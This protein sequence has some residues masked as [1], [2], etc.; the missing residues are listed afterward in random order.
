MSEAK[1]KVIGYAIIETRSQYYWVI[2]S[3]IGKAE[4]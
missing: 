2:A 3:A 4:V 1:S